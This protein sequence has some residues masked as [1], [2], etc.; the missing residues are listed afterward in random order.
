MDSDW[1]IIRERLKFRPEFR[2]SADEEL[3]CFPHQVSLHSSPFDN[4]PDNAQGGFRRAPPHHDS[5]DPDMIDRMSTPL[6]PDRELTNVIMD[7]Q[8][9]RS[10]SSSLNTGSPSPPPSLGTGPVTF[11]DTDSRVVRST[12]IPGPEQRQSLPLPP[13]PLPNIVEQLQ[14]DMVGRHFVFISD[15]S[16]VP[17]V[18]QIALFVALASGFLGSTSQAHG[19][20][21]T[22]L[23][24]KALQIGPSKNVH[25]LSSPN[26]YRTGQTMNWSQAVAIR[27]LLKIGRRMMYFLLLVNH[28]E[29]PPYKWLM[30]IT[31]TMFDKARSDPFWAFTDPPDTSREITSSSHAFQ[32]TGVTREH[33][34]NFYMDH[35]TQ[36]WTIAGSKPNFADPDFLVR[37]T[38]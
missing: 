29:L 23:C 4:L 1:D 34:S 33:V 15:F 22:V 38:E 37:I 25:I 13:P 9:Q 28:L 19:D 11:F 30:I 24:W 20:D 35:S 12:G 21:D 27:Y 6:H 7:S 18:T 14:T 31:A 2:P 3:L 17:Y 36:R 8:A 32:T 16:D 10:S 5:D 26:S